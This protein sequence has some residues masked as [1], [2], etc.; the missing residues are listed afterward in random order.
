MCLIHMEEK[1][2][3]WRETKTQVGYF[4]SIFRPHPYLL[5]LLSGEFLPQQVREL[6]EG[7]LGGHIGTG[8]HANCCQFLGGGKK[9]K[10]CSNLKPQ[11]YMWV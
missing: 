5:D 7:S 9:E 2:L 6:G 8:D 1:P 10:E 11:S 3:H 4:K